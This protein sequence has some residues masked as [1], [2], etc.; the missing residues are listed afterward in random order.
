MRVV[1][2]PALQDNYMYLVIDDSSK[3][4]AAV[5][6]VAPST[7]LKA[8]AEQGLQ[9]TS[10]LTTHHHW[11][12]AGGNVELVKSLKAQG[13]SLEVYGGGTGIAA[14]TTQVQTGDE[15]TLGDR[16]IIKCLS[17]PCHTQDHICYYA[18]DRTN[19]SDEGCV[20]TGDTLFLAGCG[21]FFEGTP[22][23][24]LQALEVLAKLPESTK[25]YCGHEY[26]LKNL[27]FAQTVEPDSIAL[28]E[29][30]ERCKLKRNSGQPTV[31]GTIAEELATNPFMRTAKPSIQ[32][33]TKTTLPVDTMEVLRHQKDAF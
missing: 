13:T 17:T 21:R 29:R 3:Q 27:Q 8:V 24:M 26:T 28:K 32:S 10:I 31:P 6:P 33:H 2:I 16:V 18:T 14:L 7:V 25:I 5:D 23:Q 11:D 20:F 9:L 15:I 1:T 12:H 19:P 30:I 22:M 4:C